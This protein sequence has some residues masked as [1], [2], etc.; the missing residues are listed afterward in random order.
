MVSAYLLD[1]N[2]L[3]DLVRN[4]RG[5]VYQCIKRKGES[6]VCT[7]IVVAAELRFGAQKK[8]SAALTERIE[9]LLSRI[10]VQAFDEPA[11]R[12]YGL[13]RQR[14]QQRGQCIGPNDLLIAAH[15]LSL[16]RVLVTDNVDEFR[17]VPDLRVENW[18][19]AC[20]E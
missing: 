15:A 20:R 4:P 5:N 18:L 2:I 7:S 14:L 1:T 12:H 9:A 6:A 10:T 17:R 3:S 13:V 11:D 8:G 19:H 16:D